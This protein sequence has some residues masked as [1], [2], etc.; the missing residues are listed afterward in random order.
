MTAIKEVE[1]GHK[2]A[3]LMKVATKSKKQRHLS[4]IRNFRYINKMA[5]ISREIFSGTL[6]SNKRKQKVNLSYPRKK[7]NYRQT[8]TEEITV[9]LSFS[10][11]T[12]TSNEKVSIRI[13]FILGKFFSLLK[14]E[15]NYL[16]RTVTTSHK[17]ATHAH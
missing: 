10:N 2:K 16:G 6:S 14:G 17:Y 8:I 7:R 1:V 11:K 4:V 3:K 5:P 9:L 13:N 15:C 12:E